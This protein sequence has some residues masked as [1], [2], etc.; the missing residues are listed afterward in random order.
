[1]LSLKKK[2]GA[3]KALLCMWGIGGGIERCDTTK[4]AT[5]IEP[6]F[7]LDLNSSI[8]GLDSGK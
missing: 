3:K 2:H 8:V 1:M 7:L 6:A 4:T 5:Q